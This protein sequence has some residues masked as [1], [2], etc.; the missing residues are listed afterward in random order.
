[1]NVWSHATC[2]LYMFLTK[3]KSSSNID[4]VC[5]VGGKVTLIPVVSSKRY[6]LLKRDQCTC[7]RV[8]YTYDIYHHLSLSGTH[9]FNVAWTMLHTL[10]ERIHVLKKRPQDITRSPCPTCTFV[11]SRTTDMQP[12]PHNRDHPQANL[13]LRGHVQDL[14]HPTRGY[15]PYHMCVATK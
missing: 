4:D 5:I 9:M 3:R 13:I 7:K 11:T 8:Q 10:Q 15:L 6:D 14:H 1:M 2:W 12:L